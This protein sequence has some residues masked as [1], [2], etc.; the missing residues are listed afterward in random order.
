V[1]GLLKNFKGN[2]GGLTRTPGS[3]VVG[4]GADGTPDDD[5]GNPVTDNGDGSITG[6]SGLAGAALS[7]GGMMLAQQG[8]LGSSRGTATG[9]AEGAL[10]GAMVGFAMGGPIGAAIGGAAGLLAGIGEVIAGVETPQREA[11]R[12]IKS[13]YGLN[14]DSNSTTI[15]QIV[16]MAKQSY[17]N[18]I[19][20]AVRSPQVRQLLQLY[21]DSTGQKSSVLMAQQ[22]H[23]ASLAESGGSLYQQATYN[24]GTPYTYASNLPTLGPTGGTLPVAQPGGAVA[25]I[26]LNPQQT[27]DLWQTGTTQ[28]I[29]NNPRAVAASSLN[30]G[31]QSSARLDTATMQM[32]PSTILS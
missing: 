29:A 13:I 17:G 27:V 26:T 1:S 5:Q 24:N 6:V 8:L 16:S 31:G 28:A 12:L 19:A 11:A 18:N 32:S 3:N 15:A 7:G 20:V 4:Y 10:G 23:S 2:L 30:G 22:V 14:I 9:V 25:N 21:A